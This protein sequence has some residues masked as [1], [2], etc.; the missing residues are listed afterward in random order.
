MVYLGSIF[1]RS[2]SSALSHPF[3]V[4]RVPLLKETKPKSKKEETNIGYPYSNLPIGGPSIGNPGFMGKAPGFYG[5][6]RIHLLS[7]LVRWP[8]ATRRWR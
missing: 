6:Y 8:H 5:L 7:H 4:G 2:P 1:S 3:L